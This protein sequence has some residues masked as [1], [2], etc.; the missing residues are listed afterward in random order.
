MDMNFK[1]LFK[2]YPLF[3]Q[4]VWKECL[5]IPKGETRTYGWIAKKVGLPGGA[6]AVGQALAKNPFAPEV[7][8]HRVIGSDGSLG[9]YSAPGGLGAKKQMLFQESKSHA[10]FSRKKK[11]KPK[12][13]GLWCQAP[14]VQKRGTEQRGRRG[15]VKG[16]ASELAPGSRFSMSGTE[17][18]LSSLPNVKFP[19][20]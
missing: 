13:S 11:K 18:S 6:R 1:E 8:C 16:K 9:G 15:V 4:K 10:R 5:K 17:G 2:P 19:S 7:P 14:F 12:E 3:Y 20:F